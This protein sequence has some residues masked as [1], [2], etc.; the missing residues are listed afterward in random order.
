MLQENSN[1]TKLPAT[2]LRPPNVAI[3]GKNCAAP[4]Q[5]SNLGPL[6]SSAD[7]LQRPADTTTAT[8]YNLEPSH[9]NM[10]RGNIF[11]YLARHELC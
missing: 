2:R 9:Y 8:Y 4:F 1:G 7:T 3:L 5:E 11:P 6:V 10:L